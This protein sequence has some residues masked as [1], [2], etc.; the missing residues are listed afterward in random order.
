MKKVYICSPYKAQDSM[1]LD[2][3]IE[4]ARELTKQALKA[5]LAPITPH[6]YLTQCLKE[7]KPEECTAGIK[8]GLEFLKSCSYVIAGV[9]YG[10]SEGMYRELEEAHRLKIVVIRIDDAGELCEH[11]RTEAAAWDFAK[12]C[13]CNFCQGNN[14]HSCTGYDC[15]EP[16]TQAYEYAIL[17][18]EIL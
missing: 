15:R 16:Y 17:H 11:I 6:L 13:A 2:R 4:Y 9:K 18:K 8:A 12:Q 10:I 3:N 14:Q 1:R 7:D 5:N